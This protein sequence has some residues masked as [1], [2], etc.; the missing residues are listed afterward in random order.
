MPLKQ[1]LNTYKQLLIIIIFMSSFF[2]QA[3]IVNIESIR[4]EKDSIG[5][6]GYAS[7]D[8]EL[9][10]N[11]NTIFTVE[12]ELRLEYKTPKSLWFFINDMDFKTINTDKIVNKST[13]H[14]RFSYKLSKI[15]SFE[16]FVQT[17]SD[18]VSEI[19]LRALL[20]AGLRFRLHKTNQYKFF[21]GTTFMYEYEKSID[22]IGE[23]LIHN[24]LRSSTYFSFKIKPSN[25]V[26]ILSTSYYQPLFN[27]ISD[28][29]ILSETSLVIQLFKNFKFRTTFSYEY[30][31]FPVSTIVKE[32][33]KLTNGIV[34]AF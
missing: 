23:Q 3:Q 22:E 31:S 24:D 20:G 17:Q 19:D 27:K 21:M 13:Q 8:I 4:K 18:R 1:C 34:Y 14:L 11:A 2:L 16:T 15:T 10:K 5:W 28:F 33:Y 29:R 7:L 26:Y 9:Q 30:D 25:S 32:Q 6:S 12:N